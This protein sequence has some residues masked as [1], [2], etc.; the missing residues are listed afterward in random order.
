MYNYLILSYFFIASYFIH[1]SY[2][3]VKKHIKDI[4]PKFKNY[5][6]SRQNYI[7]KNLIK[8]MSLYFISILSIP[9]IPAFFLNLTEFNTVIQFTGMF[10]VAN[11]F[12]GL[13][14]VDKLGLPT[15]LHHIVTTGFGLIVPMINFFEYPTARL[16]MIYTLSASYTYKVN[17]FLGIRFLTHKRE[18]LPIKKL[19]FKIYFISCICNFSF[20][21]GWLY[22]NIYN[23]TYINMFYYVIITPLIYD[24]MKL[25]AWL[26]KSEISHV[27][28]NSYVSQ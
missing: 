10:Y 4:Y 13:L 8:S 19:A 25:L 21:L 14:K 24:D 20:H 12:V 5:D 7:I 2:S 27:Q 22:L 15:K 18:Y 17:Y 6:Q 26:K 9:V 1:I 11:D 3:F 23:L 16:L 28:V